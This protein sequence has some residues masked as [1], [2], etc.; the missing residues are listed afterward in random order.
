[1][2]NKKLLRKGLIK[3]K[4]HLDL[5][6]NDIE[7]KAAKRAFIMEHLAKTQL[8]GAIGLGHTVLPLCERL[9]KLNKSS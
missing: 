7:M 8:M 3:E 1:M 4:V 6:G 5:S 9:K 2:D